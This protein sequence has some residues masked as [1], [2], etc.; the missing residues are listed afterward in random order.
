M[1]LVYGICRVSNPTIRYVGMTKNGIGRR[2]YEH[3]YAASREKPRLPLHKWMRKYDDVTY[4]I[5]HDNLTISEA[6]DLERAEI[7]AR[8]N[9][10]NCTIGG[11]G[12]MEASLETRRKMSALKKGKP[13]P[14]AMHDA[15]RKANIGRSPSPRH[16]EILRLVNTGKVLSP[17]TRAKISEAAKGRVAYNKGIPASAEARAKMSLGQLNRVK[18]ECPNCLK[19]VDPGNANR[20]HFDKCKSKP[21]A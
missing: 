3:N 5:L 16:L 8:T 1:A 14:Q 12:L 19:Q 17:E 21:M 4:V 15:A 6:Q 7:L 20:W 13:L 10:L 9:L 11:E 2:F 18:I